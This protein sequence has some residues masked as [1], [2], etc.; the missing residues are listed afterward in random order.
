[1]R[2]R[3]TPTEPSKTG[4]AW[5]FFWILAG[6]AFLASTAPTV[7]RG[8]S[9]RFLYVGHAFHSTDLYLHSLTSVRGCSTKFTE[10]V[11][12]TPGDKPILIVVRQGSPRGSLLGMVLSYLAWPRSARILTVSGTDCGP[13]L[14]RVA[15][16]SISAVAFCEV[17]PPPWLHAGVRFGSTSS[18][19]VLEPRLVAK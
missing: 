5:R 14:A 12:H 7:V 19:V 6:V 9:G 11:A 1:M 8:F 10:L 13:E 17:R 2:F 4:L 18:F 16:N 3:M 15:P